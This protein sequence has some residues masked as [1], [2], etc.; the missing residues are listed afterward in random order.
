[1]KGL[2]PFPCFPVVVIARISSNNSSN[3]LCA[4]FGGV[5]GGYWLWFFCILHLKG[6]QNFSPALYYLIHCLQISSHD[7]QN[8]KVF[9]QF[10]SDHI[11]SSSEQSNVT[12]QQLLLHQHPFSYAVTT[13]KYP[14]SDL[15]STF[16]SSA[17]SCTFFLVVL[18]N[19]RIN[20]KWGIAWVS[21]FPLK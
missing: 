5:S 16:L 17:T 2:S 9:H 11:F 20:S 21:T 10:Q 4:G 3:S 6:A 12:G 13:V 15:K 7:S 14:G 8:I 18:S 1:M 19:T